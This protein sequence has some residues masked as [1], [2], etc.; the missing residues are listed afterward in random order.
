MKEARN[1]IILNKEA[2]CFCNGMIH[3]SMLSSSLY[4]ARGD[5]WQEALNAANAKTR[6]SLNELVSHIVMRAGHHLDEIKESRRRLLKGVLKGNPLN[7]LYAL[8]VVSLKKVLSKA[9]A[10]NAGLFVLRNGALKQGGSRSIGMDYVH[11][12]PKGPLINR[13]FADLVK[14]RIRGSGVNLREL[15]K[16]SWLDKGKPEKMW[17]FLNVWCGNLRKNT[18]G[19]GH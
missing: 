19:G 6:K 1:G 14:Q 7:V 10:I 3:E 18:Y 5:T 15:L 11:A 8:I 13:I 2:F 12:V 9:I 17:R 4:L 16:K